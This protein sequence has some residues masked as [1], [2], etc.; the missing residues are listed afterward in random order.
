S[1]LEPI[2]RAGAALTVA[3]SGPSLPLLRFPRVFRQFENVDAL[4]A[5]VV[6]S[7]AD[8][9]GVTRVGIF[10]KIRQGDRYRLRAGLRCLPETHEM[11]FEPAHQGVALAKF[12]LVRFRQT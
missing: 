7:V 12:H 8:A 10:S 6:E 4:L 3:S 1:T 2:S 11:E 9:A 5:K